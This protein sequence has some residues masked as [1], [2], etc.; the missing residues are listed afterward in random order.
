[1]PQRIVIIGAGRIGRTIANLVQSAHPDAHLLLWDLNPQLV[2]HQVPLASSVPTADGVFICTPS[3]TVRQVLT[4]LQ[5]FL[6]TNTAV[7]TLAKGIEAVSGMTMAEVLGDVLGNKYPYG[8][9]GGPMLAEALEHGHRGIGVIGTTS[10]PC[11]E[12]VQSAFA[13]TPVEIQVASVPNDVALAGCLKN[14]YAFIVGLMSGLEWSV[15]ER[16]Q[17]Y[18]RIREEFLHVG[19]ALGLAPEI[20]HGAAGLGDFEETAT[21]PSSHNHHCG[22]DSAAHQAIVCTCEG[23][24]SAPSIAKRLEHLE[25][26]PLLAYLLAAMSGQRPITDLDFLRQTRAR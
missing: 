18:N 9:L 12:F 4:D 3:W 5:P 2:L 19:E 10:A 13:S 25:R 1:M 20:I 11:R 16:R 23:T 6:P 7:I 8:I 15:E 17:G 24:V 22:V 14:I 21:S 26:F